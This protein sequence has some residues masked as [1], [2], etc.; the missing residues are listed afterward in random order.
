MYWWSA[1]EA[2]RVTVDITNCY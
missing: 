1:A 2:D